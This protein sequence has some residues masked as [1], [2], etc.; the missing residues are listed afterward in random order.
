MEV[1]Y[2]MNKILRNP[3]AYTLFVLP[4]LAFFAL[5]FLDP[6][7]T[8]FKYGFTSWDGITTPVF[9]GVHN[10]T[11]ALNDEGFWRSFKN[12]VYFIVFSIFI[13]I[14]IIIFISIL[15]SSV[16]RFRG[17]YKTTVFF[18]TI[19]STAVIG[20]LWSFI[21]HPQ[22]G[23]LNQFLR[24][25]GLEHLTHAWLADKSTAMISILVTNAWQWVGFYVVLVLAAVL[26]ISK[27]VLEAAEIDGA[28]GWKKSLWITVPLI[29][30][31]IIVIILLSIIGAMKA[32]DIIIVMTDGGPYG[33]TEVMATYMYHEAFKGREYGYANAI[34]ILIML[35]TF[36]LTVVFRMISERFEEV[37]Y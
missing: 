25:I 9:N 32:L 33:L 11:Q 1:E 14:P 2:T 35:F 7:I 28:S 36:I 31:V 34:A 23:L 22:A 19:L 29:R 27:E 17:F 6:M 3:L 24:G 37:D 10:F 4:T 12:N 8:A 18:P 30:P 20:V 5:F 26:G 21:Y 16:Q 13:Q 15:I